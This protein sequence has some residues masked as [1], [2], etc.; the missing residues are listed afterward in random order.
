MSRQRVKALE[1]IFFLFYF[2]VLP[3]MNIAQYQTSN[4]DHRVLSN[5]SLV[6]YTM[7][8]IL[9]GLFFLLYYKFVL[10]YFLRKKNYL[11]FAL[12][13]IAIIFLYELYLRGLDHLMVLLPF[14]P[15]FFQKV[16]QSY[17]DSKLVFRQAL[18][19]TITHL[20][21]L[22]ALGFFIK[23]ITDEANILKLK[24]QRTQLELHQLRTQLQPHFFFNTLNNIY[25]L[26]LARSEKTAHSISQ[27]SEIMRYII[28]ECRSEK[29]SLSKEV[30]FIENYIKLERIRYEQPE[31]VFQYQGEMAG[32]FIEP[33][34]FIP[35][36]EN[37]FKHG[38]HRANDG[39]IHIT[40]VAF[41]QEVMLE[42]KNNKPAVN[43]SG[44]KGIGLSNFKKQLELLYPGKHTVR[45]D[46][47]NDT[48]AVFIT[49]KL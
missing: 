45:I 19:F 7:T 33:L 17:I 1:I 29:I 3:I 15:E 31:I 42:V 5:D 23:T 20:I 27:L 10:P 49:L 22:S 18:S 28:Y 39:W 48:Y 13:V 36:I 43:G 47:T 40:L 6:Y 14:V 12:A 24:E 11:T 37:A 38:I 32:V 2:I 34:L 41:D 46:D 4:S 44:K 30:A 25:S 21:S 8:G 16:S 35:V 9:S 26:A